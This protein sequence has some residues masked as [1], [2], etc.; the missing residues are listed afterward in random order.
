MLLIKF[1]LQM[2]KQITSLDDLAQK[3]AVIMQKN[4]GSFS[5]E[6][7]VALANC[8]RVIEELKQLKADQPDKKAAYIQVI[9]KILFKVFSNSE[10]IDWFADMF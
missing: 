6:E 4:R 10:V 3:V 2:E 5:N 7:L 8:I 9:L 1:L